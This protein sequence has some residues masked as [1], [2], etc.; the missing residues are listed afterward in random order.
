MKG[1]KSEKGAQGEGTSSKRAEEESP[2]GGIQEAMGRGG[3]LP[4]QSSVLKRLKPRMSS[5]LFVNLLSSS[6]L[7]LFEISLPIGAVLLHQ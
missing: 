6:S 1:D 4:Q 7:K 2:D 3:E 5:T